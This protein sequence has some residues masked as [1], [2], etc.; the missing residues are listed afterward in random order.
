PPVQPLGNASFRYLPH[1]VYR[2]AG[3]DDWISLVVRSDQEWRKLCGLI[4]GLAQMASLGF[5]QRAE[6]RTAID[7]AL[8]TWLRPRAARDT[9]AELRISGI[10]AEALASSLDLV[11]DNHLHN[12][13]FWQSDSGGVLPGLPWRASFGRRSGVAPTLGADT[14]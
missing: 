7:R 1:G 13:G 12:R 9:A 8:S 3:D 5:G 11:K 4:P 2:C 6:R 10:P 14:E